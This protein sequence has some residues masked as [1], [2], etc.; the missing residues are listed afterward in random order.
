MGIV[1][2]VLYLAVFL[3]AGFVLA[4]RAL[5]AAGPETQLVFTAA[6]GLVRLQ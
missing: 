6:F 3:T 5:P 4:R 1:F 2:S